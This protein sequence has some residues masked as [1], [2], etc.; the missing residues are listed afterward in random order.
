MDTYILNSR[1][2]AI[3]SCRSV[4]SNSLFYKVKIS[5]SS[6]ISARNREKFP[7]EMTP[8]SAENS[9]TA[10]DNEEEHAADHAI[11][12]DLDTRSSTVANSGSKIWLKVELANT[13]CIHQVVWYRSTGIPHLTWTCSSTDC[14]TCMGTPTHCPKYSLT[15]SIKSSSSDDLPSQPDCKYGD[16]VMLEKT[17]GDKFGVSELVLIGKQGEMRL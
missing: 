14:S 6:Y 8:I 13:A 9:R 3:R 1:K 5:Y 2:V 11:D 4:R 7:N 16:T 12:L 17:D 15:V 10:D